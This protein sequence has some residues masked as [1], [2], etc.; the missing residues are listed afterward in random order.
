MKKMYVMPSARAKHASL[1]GNERL[2]N[3][4]A[5]LDPLGRGTTPLSRRDGPATA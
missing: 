1:A 4:I 3:V 2:A 5:T